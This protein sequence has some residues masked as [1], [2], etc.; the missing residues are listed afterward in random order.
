[1]KELS[2]ADLLP[3]DFVTKAPFDYLQ[4]VIEQVE[5]LPK[6]IILHASYYTTDNMYVI[7]FWNDSGNSWDI[8][9]NKSANT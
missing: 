8:Y 2:E 1:M 9:L 7:H 6:G 4:S 5:S 3:D